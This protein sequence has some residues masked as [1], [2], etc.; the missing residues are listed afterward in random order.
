MTQLQVVKCEIFLQAAP[1]QA[2][3]VHSLANPFKGQQS[4]GPITLWL[5][6]VMSI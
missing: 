6:P 3:I 4:T 1:L 5:F 2:V